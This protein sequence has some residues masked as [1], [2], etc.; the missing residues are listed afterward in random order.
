M[1]YRMS[2][3]APKRKFRVQTPRQAGKPR[4]LV[5]FI[6]IV[7]LIQFWLLKTYFREIE[8]KL[9]ED[10]F[11]L[12]IK[13]P[14]S[15]STLMKSYYELGKVPVDISAPKEATASMANETK[16]PEETQTG[17]AATLSTTETESGLSA[18]ETPNSLF[19]LSEEQKKIIFRA[20]ELLNENIEY[21]YQY[22]PETGYPTDNKWISTDVVAMV[23]KDC[24]YDLMELIY[25]DMSE[26]K[27]AYP[28]DLKGSKNLDKYMDFRQVYFQ[29]TFFKRYALEL[30][31][32]Y[33]P[34]DETNNLQWQPGDVV[35]FEV[36]KD[37]PGKDVVGI[38]SSHKND[39]G[40]PLVIMCT[41]D[42]GK[43][44]EVDVLEEYKIKGHYR[45]PYPEVD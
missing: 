16:E 20:L 17:G 41:K 5:Y 43:L 21:G 42:L 39:R 15:E 14:I 34:G 7:A 1:E 32:E 6:I 10:L 23:L 35:F 29:E 30:P 18:S 31:S 33:I 3:Q 11:S 38:I 4:Y 9:P 13:F 36:D 44:S 27:E 37:N 26:H 28:M 40:V 25:K 19:S 8:T 45:Y 2:S 22:Y 24:G 12:P